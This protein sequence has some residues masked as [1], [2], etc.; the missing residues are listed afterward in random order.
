MEPFD[1]PPEWSEV[2]R[3]LAERQHPQPS[4]AFRERVLTAMRAERA[5]RRTSW[6]IAA[7]IAASLLLAL[8]SAL[9]LENHRAW[10]AIQ[11]IEN[12]GVETTART[13]RQRHPELS[14]R[15]AYQFALVLHSPPALP[16]SLPP[17]LPL[18][19]EQSWDMP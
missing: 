17:L 13:L 18:E 11:R 7:L 8:N 5:P 15:Q 6:K 1:F 3:R 14:E 2:E 16:L 10:A 12:E 4:A 19:G 9:S